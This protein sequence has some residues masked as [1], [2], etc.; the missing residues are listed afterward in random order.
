MEAAAAGRFLVT[1]EE[2]HAAVAR[3]GEDLVHGAR[4]RLPALGTI[5]T[6]T[7]EAN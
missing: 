5:T 2:W 7:T 6:P 4:P 1:P 3:R